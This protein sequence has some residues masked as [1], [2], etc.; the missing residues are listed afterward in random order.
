MIIF[1][2]IMRTRFENEPSKTW[3]TFGPSF[4]HIPNVPSG[5]IMNDDDILRSTIRAEAEASEHKTLARTPTSRADADFR[6]QRCT[7]KSIPVWDVCEA[8]AKALAQTPTRI[9]RSHHTHVYR[10][11]PFEPRSAP[12]VYH[13]LTRGVACTKWYGDDYRPA[14]RLHGGLHA[15]DEEEEER[16]PSSQ[17]PSPPLSAYRNFAGYY[18]S[19]ISGAKS[20]MRAPES[21]YVPPMI[22][23]RLAAESALRVWDARHRGSPTVLRV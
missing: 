4:F 2:R 7:R 19:R 22:R 9:S 23:R 12:D 6:P 13:L 1:A 14:R 15:A 20:E 10:E 5:R 17:P 18:R 16:S 3:G 11:P 8:A 21:A